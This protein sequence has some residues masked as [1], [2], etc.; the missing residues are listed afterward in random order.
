MSFP[1]GWKGK[2][3]ASEEGT[4][5]RGAEGGCVDASDVTL[6]HRAGAWPSAWPTPYRR[7]AKGFRSLREMGHGS[8]VYGRLLFAPRTHDTLRSRG[9]EGGAEAVGARCFRAPGDT[10]PWALTGFAF[11]SAPGVRLVRL[12]ILGLSGVLKGSR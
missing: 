1:G 7:Q 2:A 9:L 11:V 12:S 6:C 5:L 8:C 3:P 10:A 4:S